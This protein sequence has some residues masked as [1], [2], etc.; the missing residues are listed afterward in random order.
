MA[1]LPIYNSK[2]EI[3]TQTPTNIRNPQDYNLMGNALQNTSKEIQRLSA[4]WQQAKDQVENLDGKNK[5]LMGISDVLTEA[6]QYSD[7]KTPEELESKKQELSAK[8]HGILPE[9]VGGFSNN[10]NAVLFQ[11]QGEYTTYQNQVKLDEIFRNKYQDKAYENIVQS[12]DMNFRNF[13]Q[14]GNKAYKQNYYNDIDSMVN[15]GFMTKEDGA[16]NKLAVNDW[17]AE[18]AYNAISKNPYAQ[19]PDEIMKGIDPRKQTQLRNFARTEKNRVKAENLLNLESSFFA[20]PTQENLDKIIKANPKGNY[21]KLQEIVNSQPNYE[22]ISNIKGLQEGLDKIKEL[23]DI[24]TN[25]YNGKMQYIANAGLL[26]FSVIK[27]NVRKDGEATLSDSDKNKLVETIYKNMGNATFKEQISKL[28]D[29]SNL[30]DIELSNIAGKSYVKGTYM[31]FHR[32]TTALNKFRGKDSVWND[33]GI[34]NKLDNI[35]KRTMEGVLNSV[36]NGDFQTAEKIY[37]TG[38]QAAIKTK[39]WYVP[40]L[41]KTDLQAGQKFTLNGRVYTFQGFSNK[42]IIVEAN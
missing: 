41:Q 33:I 30:K 26:A 15:A 9:V 16:K 25:S 6:E 31:D 35:K 17:N 18:Y 20:N 1:K 37:N 22:T 19:I 13:I 40:E 27:N 8:L 39:Y 2:G 5:L 28:P 23:A 21:S 36:V 34:A 24:D 42:D 4:Q 29:L 38:L 12:E 3:T 14:T 11:K 32:D 10:Q 7:W